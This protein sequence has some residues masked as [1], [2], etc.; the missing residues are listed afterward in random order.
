M[1]GK[2]WLAK[3]DWTLIA[4]AL[5]LAGA[6]LSVLV[7]A[8]YVGPR[9]PW[10]FADL[11]TWMPGIVR[12]QLVFFTLSLAVMLIAMMVDY[13]HVET[14]AFLLYGVGVVFLVLVHLVGETRSGATRWIDFGPVAFQPSES[15]K[16][17]VVFALARY[18]AKREPDDERGYYLRELVVPFSIVAVPMVLVVT[19][20]DL[21]TAML[22]T[23]VG[24][25]VLLCVGIRWKSLV[26]LALVGALA[27][28]VAWNYVL[29]DYQKDRVRTFLDPE[30][31]PKGTGYHIIQSKIAV[32][33]GRLTGKGFLQG[34]QGT[35]QFLPEHHTDFIFSVLAEERGWFGCMTVVG[36]YLALLLR[37]LTIAQRAK[38]RFGAF[39]A[40]GLTSILFWHVVVNVN[41]VTGSLPVVG[42]PLP[43][44]SY[45]GTFLTTTFLIVGLLGNVSMR[46]FMF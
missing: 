31:D 33:S 2:R 46:R 19:Q 35:L 25:S 37:G 10:S 42:V 7:S 12:R 18:F 20:P 44:L 5:A 40:V 24:M 45:G 41:M 28:P 16:M 11:V 15:M 29:K 26:L 6:G 17:L 8:T 30:R 9:D 13:R 27:V 43:F 21:G 4:L 23:F 34:T 32:G 38:D 39:L 3:V 36:L 1:N 22:I 14:Y